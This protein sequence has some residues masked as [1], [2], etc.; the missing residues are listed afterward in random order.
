MT[1]L[2]ATAPSQVFGLALLLAIAVVHDMRAHR[3]PNILVLI[4]I[5]LAASLHALALGKGSES[6]AGQAWWSPLAG[7]LTGLATL[8]P[9]YL[10]RATGAGDV[11]LMGMVGTFIG[12][13]AV[14]AATFYTFLAGGLLS[15]AFM[16]RPGVARQALDNVR[17]LVSDWVLRAHTGQSLNLRLAP[18]KS[19]AA[20]LPYAV[21]IALG[22]GVALRWPLISP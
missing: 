21:A 18:L 20:R 5:A 9:L 17:F 10:L 19:T 11:K 15:L 3:I 7:L 1:A 6:L 22:T 2:S 16:L 8:M 4:G 12:T 14:L 13:Q